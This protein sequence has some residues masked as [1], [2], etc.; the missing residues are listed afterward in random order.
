VGPLISIIIPARNEE[1]NIGRCLGSLVDQEGAA[2][3]ITV[4]DDHSTDRT[5]EIAAS[6]PH[7][8][9]MPANPLPDGW[10]GKANAIQSA[11]PWAV[12]EWLLF[13]DAD[14]VHAPGA[15]ARSLAE[16]EEYG[17]AMLSYSPGQETGGFWERAVQPVIFAELSRTFAYEEINREGSSIAAANGQYI[18]VRRAVYEAVGGHIAVRGSLLEDVE[19]ARRVKRI[20]RLRFRYAPD[21]VSARMY[22]STRDLV[23]GWTKNLAALFPNALPLAALRA[24]ESA[25]LIGGPLALVW[26]PWGALSVLAYAGFAQRLRKGGW[27]LARVPAAILGLPFFAWLLL[28][29]YWMYSIR[30]RV[31]WKGR[32]Y[33]TDTTRSESPRDRCP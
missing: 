27:S 18:L 3:E 12:G 17:A 4:V 22:R 13:T 9:V 11:V 30:K 5:A 14:T 31:R 1:A 21:A 33:A 19:L 32:S 16:A 26:T 20:G 6:F 24:L 29:S 23:E 2:F 28:R 25:I 15:L 8:R 10:T 7:V